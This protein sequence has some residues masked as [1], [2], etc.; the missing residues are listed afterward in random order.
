[1]ER[2]ELPFDDITSSLRQMEEAV[3]DIFFKDDGRSSV[4][5]QCHAR[6]GHLPQDAPGENAHHFS[7]TSRLSTESVQERRQSPEIV[8]KIR[9][10]SSL[11]QWI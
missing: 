3:E 8:F 9:S 5:S 2:L 11:D 10:V 7:T 6:E 4:V 1:M